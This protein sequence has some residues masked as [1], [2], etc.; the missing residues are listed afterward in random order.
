MMPY[1]T[2]TAANTGLTVAANIYQSVF[3]TAS[4]TTDPLAAVTQFQ[5]QIGG[6]NMFQQNF[7][8]DFEKF[9]NETSAMNEI[10]GGLSTGITNELIG[11]Y[12]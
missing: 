11:H 4:G 2:G 6:Q 3:D 1:L 8:Y 5:V 10:N 12:E 9:I 7:Q